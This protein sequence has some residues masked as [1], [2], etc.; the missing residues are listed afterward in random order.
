MIFSEKERDTS[1]PEKNYPLNQQCHR[2]SALKEWGAT[3]AASFLSIA[4]YAENT[5][6]RLYFY[7]MILCIG[8]VLTPDELDD[9]SKRLT[10]AEFE[11]EKRSLTESCHID[12]SIN[13]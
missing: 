2:I 12:S 8:E 13:S 9:I 5:T 1:L 7:S 11:R 10:D 3:A 4:G 6:Y